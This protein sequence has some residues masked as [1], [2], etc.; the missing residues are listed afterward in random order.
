M[1]AREEVGKPG[2]REVI[3]HTPCPSPGWGH[4]Q[5]A[6]VPLGKALTCWNQTLKKIHRQTA[7]HTET[8]QLFAQI[9]FPYALRSP[10]QWEASDPSPGYPITVEQVGTPVPYNID[11]D[12][13]QRLM[14]GGLYDG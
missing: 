11:R 14:T 10:R 5:S 9:R 6:K 12:G 8:P 2:S 7:S 1:P 4:S 3:R 13:T